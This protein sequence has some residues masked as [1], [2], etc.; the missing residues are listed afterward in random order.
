M[1]GAE[2]DPGRRRDAG[3]AGGLQPHRPGRH[4]RVAVDRLIV[5]ER[6]MAQIG[7]RAQRRPVLQQARAA[8][9]EHLV[10]QQPLDLE[11]G[12]IPG[13]VADR[14]VEIALNQIDD[15]VGR[16]NPHIDLDMGLLEPVQAHHQPFGGEG[17]R[18]G[19]RQGPGIVMGAQPAHRGMDAGKGFAEA[20]QQDARRGGQLDRAVEAVKQPDPE[21]L[22]ERVDLMADRGRRHAEFVGGFA[23]AHQPGGRLKRAQRAQG[24]EAG[25]HRDE[26]S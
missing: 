18:S 20:G 1:A 23:E 14:D 10:L 8:R 22:L 7:R 3:D 21:I 2:A 15:L 4:Q 13:A 5:N 17:G 11:P 19:D 24:R 16:G 6:V 12:I 9:R 26:F 25:V